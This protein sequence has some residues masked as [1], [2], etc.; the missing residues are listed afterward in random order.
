L[1]YQ[2]RRGRTS[3]NTVLTYTGSDENRQ[4]A[5]GGYFLPMERIVPQESVKDLRQHI[6]EL[7]QQGKDPM[8]ALKEYA[9]IF[10]TPG[11]GAKVSGFGR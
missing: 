5:M 4:R 9:D 7:R 11:L 8:D 3:S 2:H 10:K 1:T 6:N